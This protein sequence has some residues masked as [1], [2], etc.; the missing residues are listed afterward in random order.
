MTSRSSFISHF[1]DFAQPIT[2]NADTY[3]SVIDTAK[4]NGADIGAGFS[5]S[6][7]IPMIA[8]V[9]GISIYA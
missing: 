6:K 8:V 9:A 1:N 4:K 7:T 3:H 2:G 5:F